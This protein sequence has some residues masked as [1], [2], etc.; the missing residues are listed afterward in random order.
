MNPNL[1]NE[2]SLNVYINSSKVSGIRRARYFQKWGV[3]IMKL[4]EEQLKKLGKFSPIT[5]R[6]TSNL[7]SA[8]IS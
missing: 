8:D 1:S 2:E 4:G 5:R 6:K 3:N 7:F